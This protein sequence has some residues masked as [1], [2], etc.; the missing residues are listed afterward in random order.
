MSDQQV[1]VLDDRAHNAG[2]AVR[3]QRSIVDLVND[4]AASAHRTMLEEEPVGPTGELQK[5]TL[6]DKADQA[7]AA[8]R[9]ISAAVIITPVLNFQAGGVTG[10]G[11]PGILGGGERYPLD[12]ALGTGIYGDKHEPVVSP[13]GGVMVYRSPRS[14]SFRLTAHTGNIGTIFTHSTKG[15][16]PNPYPER[17]FSRTAEETPAYIKMWGTAA[18]HSA[19]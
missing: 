1:H 16:E 12:V 3:L 15:Q 10:A 8:S 13:F 14:V 19:V 7:D 17:T 11:R 9:K 18:T 4:I 6:L 2:V 5:H